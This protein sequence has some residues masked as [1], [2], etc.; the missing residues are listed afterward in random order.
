MAYAL[1]VVEQLEEG[2]P[3]EVLIPEGSLKLTFVRKVDTVTVSEFIYATEGSGNHGQL[4]QEW[5]RFAE[6]A[7]VYLLSE[8]A[9]LAQHPQVGNWFRQET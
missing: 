9:G 3:A 4:V 1:E 8:F 6:E 5:K 7:R 2:Q